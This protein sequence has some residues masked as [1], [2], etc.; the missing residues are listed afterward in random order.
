MFTCSAAAI[1]A[2]CFPESDQP[3]PVV[4]MKGMSS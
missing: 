1:S 3:T 2:G 4:R